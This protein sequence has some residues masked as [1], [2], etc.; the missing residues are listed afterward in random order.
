MWSHREGWG[1]VY[2]TPATLSGTE[3]EALVI[4][5]SDLRLARLGEYVE[6][7]DA[8]GIRIG[9]V[10]RATLHETFYHTW[11]ELEIQLA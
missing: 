1:W 4:Q 6:V 5:T 2:R 8:N 10:V 7:Y 9:Q 3:A 11:A